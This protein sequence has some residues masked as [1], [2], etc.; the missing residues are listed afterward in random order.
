M[1]QHAVSVLL[2]HS[3]QRTAKLK[4]RRAWVIFAFL[5]LA[6]F[7]RNKKQLSNSKF[8]T[9]LMQFISLEAQ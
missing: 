6:I 3:K 7:P 4:Q 9:A 5:I 1:H 2:D 8:I